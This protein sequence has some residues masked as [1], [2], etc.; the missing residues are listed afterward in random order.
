MSSSD[1]FHKYYDVF[2]N[3]YNRT[4]SIP[5]PIPELAIDS[6]TENCESSPDELI[7]NQIEEIKAKLSSET[8][9]TDLSSNIRILPVLVEQIQKNR[10]PR[11]TIEVYLIDSIKLSFWI[12]SAPCAP[13]TSNIH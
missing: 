10:N 2:A 12:C 3:P 4:R 7:L 1:G 8:Y 5:K 9:T 13:K 6:M 11:V